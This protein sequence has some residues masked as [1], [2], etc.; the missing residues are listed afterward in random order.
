[1]V[2]VKYEAL[3]QIYVNDKDHLI[4]IMKEVLN[5]KKGI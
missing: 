1:M 3:R 4:M 5:Q 2:L